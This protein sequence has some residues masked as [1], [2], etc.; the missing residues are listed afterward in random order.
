VFDQLSGE[1]GH[2][3]D[4]HEHDFGS[5]RFRQFAEI[6]GAF[7]F[8]GVF[9]SCENGELRAEVAVGDGN[10]CV[11]WSG[12]GAGDAG[13]HFEA[14]SGGAQFLRFLSS[15]AEHV[16][17]AAFEPGDGFSGEHFL[18]E[19]G[20]DAVLGKG[21]L[22]GLLAHVENLRI[23]AG[24]LEHFLVHEVIVGDHIG[25]ADAFFGAQ[26]DQSEIPWTG[27]NQI[28]DSPGG[29]FGIGH[30]AFFMAASPA[31]SKPKLSAPHVLCWGFGHR[32]SR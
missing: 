27:S 5:V 2:A 26:G 17:V 31:A 19:Q 4:A 22:V 14:A 10:A 3:P 24:P 11:G 23:R 21:V 28:A 6:E 8:G 32:E 7:L 12:N 13:N 9:V 29:S 16:G 20:I 15:A 18:N 25:P 1:D 30:A